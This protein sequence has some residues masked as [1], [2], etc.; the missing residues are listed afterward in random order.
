MGSYL[1]VLQVVVE[2]LIL[3]NDSLVLVGVSVRETSSLSRLAAHQTVE[4]R[5]NLVGTALL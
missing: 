1:G 2:G 5:S 3:P 4:V